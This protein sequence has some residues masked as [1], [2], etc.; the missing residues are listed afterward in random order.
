MIALC[1]S[2]QSLGYLLVSHYI[3]KREKRWGE[4]VQHMRNSLGQKQWMASITQLRLWHLCAL[5]FY[6]FKPSVRVDSG[7]LGYVSGTLGTLDM[8]SHRKCSCPLASRLRCWSAFESI[9]QMESGAWEFYRQQGSMLL[10][11]LILAQTKPSPTF[12]KGAEEGQIL[13]LYWPWF[14]NVWFECK[15]SSTGWCV[16]TLTP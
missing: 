6:Y 4:R 5:L 2:V 13:P 14:W 9:L 11:L 1:Y 15:M 16:W 12:P 8:S 10:P 7:H 3:L